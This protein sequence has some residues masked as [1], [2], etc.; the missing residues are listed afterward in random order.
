M[1]IIL[2]IRHAENDFVKE[3]RLAGRIPGVHL[4]QAGM[5]QA[6]ELADSLKEIPFSAVYCSPLERAVE[7]AECLIKD[8]NVTILKEQALNEIDYGDWQGE[9]VSHL[10]K[11]ALWKKL[12]AAPSMIRFPNGESLLEAQNRAIH[13]I[14][15]L[16]NLWNDKEFIVCVTHADIIKLIVAYYLGLPI[17]HYNRMEISTASITAMSFHKD[18]IRL[19]TLSS[20]SISHFA[21][22][23]KGNGR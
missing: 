9:K 8:R 12:M 22:K 4:N 14:F 20:H 18:E 7:T 3:G 17:D 19:L 16:P 6:Q 10:N 21:V 1:A 23:I 2:F 5:K 15:S 11:I 13:F